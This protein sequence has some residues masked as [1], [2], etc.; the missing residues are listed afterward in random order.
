MILLSP[1]T[2]EFTENAEGLIFCSG[3]EGRQSKKPSLMKITEQKEH[4]VVIL[5]F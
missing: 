4:E 2:L 1:A 5:P 3:R